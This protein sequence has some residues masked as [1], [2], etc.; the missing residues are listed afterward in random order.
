MI[1]TCLVF[2]AIA[3]ANRYQIGSSYPCW[4]DTKNSLMIQW[5]QPNSIAGLVL[6]IPT[7]ISFI[8]TYKFCK[9]IK[10]HQTK[11]DDF[12]I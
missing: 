6:I 2:D 8:L 9:Q 1:E 12:Q 3:T 11:Q 4:Y 7:I 5:E 10:R